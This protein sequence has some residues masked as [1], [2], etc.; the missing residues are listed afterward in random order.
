MA[1]KCG[2]CGGNDTC[3][4]GHSKGW[5]LENWLST[6]NQLSPWG[7]GAPVGG[8]VV[9]VGFAIDRPSSLQRQLSLNSGCD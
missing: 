2:G 6:K 5:D 4:K 9:A 3:S 7:Y 8:A 1:V